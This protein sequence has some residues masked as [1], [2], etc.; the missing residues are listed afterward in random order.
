MTARLQALRAFEMSIDVPS[1]GHP[2][3]KLRGE[4]DQ[5]NVPKLA[6]GLSALG[7]A[8]WSTILVD[9]S[10]TAF[11]DLSGARA[12]ADVH[13]HLC[14]MA[15]GCLILSSP[16]ANVSRLLSFTGLDRLLAPSM[17][18]RVPPDLRERISA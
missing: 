10:N 9:L 17:D 8:G 4:V 2:V 1:Q 15:G 14:Q 7:E 16:P 11:L 3:V 12:L 18:G 5:A 13:A 6:R